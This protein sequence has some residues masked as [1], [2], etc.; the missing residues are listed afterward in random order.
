MGD[1]E[2]RQPE[3]FV[4]TDEQLAL[5]RHRYREA[6]R[7][8]LT[9]R[10]AKLFAASTSLDIQAMRDLAEHGCPSHLILLIL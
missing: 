10:D 5:H 6:R 3:P 2:T 4:L 8:G 7:A 1:Q 9:M